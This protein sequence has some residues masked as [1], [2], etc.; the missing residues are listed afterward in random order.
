M[1]VVPQ[2]MRPLRLRNCPR[3]GLDSAMRCGDPASPHP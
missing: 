1:F 3:V 2:L